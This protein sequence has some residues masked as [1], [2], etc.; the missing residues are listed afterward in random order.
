[1]WLYLP[2]GKLKVRLV[3]RVNLTGVVYS[4]GDT[5]DRVTSVLSK[6]PRNA[7]LIKKL[8]PIWGLDKEGEV[9]GVWGYNKL[10]VPGLWYMYGNLATCRFYSMRIAL[11]IKAM[12]EGIWSG[13]YED[14]GQ[15]SQVA[16]PQNIGCA[17]RKVASE[18]RTV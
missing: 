10:G 16:A 9:S 4:F 11:Q 7:N 8:N 5:L 13:V 17:I 15:H 3:F 18:T 2:L 6:D 14:P 12:E 1:M